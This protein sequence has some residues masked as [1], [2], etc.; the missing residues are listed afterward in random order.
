MSVLFLELARTILFLS[1]SPHTFKL[2]MISSMVVLAPNGKVAKTLPVVRLA[3]H[4]LIV[5]VD[6]VVGVELL[7]TTIAGKHMA[8]V[9]PHFVLARNLQR[10]E[11]FV[12]NITEVNPLSLSCALSPYTDPIQQQH[13]FPH[14][15]ALDTCRPRCQ[16]MSTP[17]HELLKV[18]PGLEGDEADDKAD[19]LVC[20]QLHQIS[21]LQYFLE[22]AGSM[23]HQHVHRQDFF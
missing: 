16:K 2:R 12:T 22:T 3:A 10:L 6:A 20:L 14:K 8:T 13:D 4:K 1:S 5:S 11:S 21:D 17:L 19:P 9:L 15:P 18:D 7:A 23:Y